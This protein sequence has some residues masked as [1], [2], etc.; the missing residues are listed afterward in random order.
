MRRINR[1]E[2]TTET[3]EEQRENQ[4]YNPTFILLYEKQRLFLGIGE[5]DH[6][7]LFRHK[8]DLYG[9]STNSRYEYIGCEHWVK[10]D[11]QWQP[12]SSVFLQHADLTE[13]FQSNRL[14]FDSSESKTVKAL[15]DYLH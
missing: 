7:T 11:K 4:H 15:T 10:Y 5:S 9:L 1:F 14:S 8:D 12:C 2:L 13:F 6:F 3:P